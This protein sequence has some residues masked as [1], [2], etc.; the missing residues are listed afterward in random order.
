[1]PMLGH[2]S[3]FGRSAR[4]RIRKP[5]LSYVYLRDGTS[6]DL[7]NVYA[8]ITSNAVRFRDGADRDAV[9]HQ[10]RRTSYQACMFLMPLTLL[11]TKRAACKGSFSGCHQIQRLLMSFIINTGVR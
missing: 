5:H 6:A 3:I 1:M 7:F 2:Q 4:P 9:R 10:H 11:S 8:T